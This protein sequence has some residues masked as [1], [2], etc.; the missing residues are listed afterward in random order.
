MASV[1]RGYQLD[2]RTTNTN[3]EG[4]GQTACYWAY[5]SHR[6][7][8]ICDIFPFVAAHI[9]IKLITTSLR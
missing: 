5:P 7:L 8:P 9:H 4:P 2:Q 3:K 6:S 1:L